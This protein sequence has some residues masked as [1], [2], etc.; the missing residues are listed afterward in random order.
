M[1]S[2]TESVPGVQAGGH[3][4]GQAGGHAGQA[5]PSG[6]DTALL[7]ACIDGPVPGEALVAAADYTDRATSAR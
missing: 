2:V 4:E 1:L 5:A 7:R 6:K 3:G